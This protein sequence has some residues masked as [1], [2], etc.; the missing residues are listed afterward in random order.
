MFPRAR[1][2]LAPLCGLVLLGRRI[3]TMAIVFVGFSVPLGVP[4]LGPLGTMPIIKY[5]LIT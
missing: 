1:L 2:S 3:P 4:P 5:D